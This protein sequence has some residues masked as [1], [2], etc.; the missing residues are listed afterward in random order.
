MA[1][2]SAVA[3][4]PECGR[5]KPSRGS[6]M[7][8]RRIWNAAIDSLPNR[9]FHPCAHEVLRERL[10]ARQGRRGTPATRPW[11]IKAKDSA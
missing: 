5:P 8:E 9:W 2:K 10:L 6:D 7:I 3:P 1:R 11:P 4:V